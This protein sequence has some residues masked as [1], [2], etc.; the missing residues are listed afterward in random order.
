MNQIIRMNIL[1]NAERFVIQQFK[2][3]L[4]PV[5]SFHNLDHTKRVVEAAKLLAE[6]EHISE[7]DKEILLLAAWFHDVGYCVSCTKHENIGM[8]VAEQFLKEQNLNETEIQQVT[9]LISATA[10]N[11]IPEN[12]LEKIIKDADTSHISAANFFEITETL[13]EECKMVHDMK[14]SKKDWATQNLIFLTKH[15]YFTEFARN[16]WEELKQK[17]IAK[18]KKIIAELSQNNEDKMALKEEKKLIN[19]K[20]L[21]KMDSPERG[22][23]T[24]FRV[25]LSNHTQLSQIADT[26]ANILLSVNAIIISVALSTIVPKLD[27]PKN[28]HLIIPTFLL[29]IF[30][31]ATIIMAIASTRP[32][33]SSGSFT[34]KDIEE[35]KINLL[36]FGNFHKVPLEEYMWAMKEM[37]KDRTYLY[38]SMIKD[39]YYLG[40]VLNRKYRLLRTTYTI[41]SIGI[42]VSVLAFYLAFKEVI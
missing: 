7:K 10:L 5:Y 33:I 40:I 42:I 20:K 4:S 39:L 36:F 3:K 17:N 14:L 24:M 27:A 25:T 23:E 29:I 34:R 31:V 15:Q 8:E 21:E 1:D 2:D 19:K 6:K 41:F 37:M 11:V 26:K 12:I 28:S 13:R 38:D 16:N 35:R 32:K 9:K 30:S 22:V 18:T